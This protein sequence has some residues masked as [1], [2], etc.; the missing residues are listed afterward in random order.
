MLNKKEIKNKLLNTY[1]YKKLRKTTNIC[2]T[3]LIG[4][5]ASSTA[6]DS[7]DIDIEI[8]IDQDNID[9]IDLN[10][11]NTHVFFHKPS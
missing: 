4:S 11:S 2:A 3:L 10:L 6:L 9:D 7:S 1:A 5:Q 8:I